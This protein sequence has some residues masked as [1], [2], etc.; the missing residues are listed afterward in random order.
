MTQYYW[1]HIIH[2][3]KLNYCDTPPDML[4]M[5]FPLLSISH[6]INVQFP[7]LTSTKMP[8]LGLNIEPCMASVSASQAHVYM[9]WHSAVT[10]WKSQTFLWHCKLLL[11]VSVLLL[12]LLICYA[13]WWNETNGKDNENCPVQLLSDLLTSLLFKDF[14]ALSFSLLNQL[15]SAPPSSASSRAPELTCC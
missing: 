6:N 1:L 14:G 3:S 12:G 10:W 4:L 15:L 7:L 9:I 8:S 5:T 13:L 11:V 2:S